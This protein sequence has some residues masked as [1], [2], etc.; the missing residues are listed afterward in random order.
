MDL[1][2]AN[3]TILIEHL[4]KGNKKAFDILFTKYY[5]PLCAFANQYVDFEDSEEI[6][7]DIMVWFWENRETFV[8]EVSLKGYLFKMVKNKCFTLITR[9]EI[10]Q[11]VLSTLH[12]KMQEKFDNPDFYDEEELSNKIKNAISKLPE[13]YREAFVLHRFHNM[14]YKQIAERLQ[15]ST[16]T[17]DYRICQALKT[18]RIELKDYIWLL[19]MWLDL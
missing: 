14:T 17:V 18:L 7:Q 9:N 16:K 3:D 15:V 4:Q 10:K 12:Q 13:A 8:F 5:S 19:A 1:K 6:V 11:R 2:T